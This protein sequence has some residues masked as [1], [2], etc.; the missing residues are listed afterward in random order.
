MQ[1][2]PWLGSNVTSSFELKMGAIRDIVDTKPLRC[3]SKWHYV[4]LCL[5][6]EEEKWMKKKDTMYATKL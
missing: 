2:I 5:V 6:F 1:E 3:K 4:K